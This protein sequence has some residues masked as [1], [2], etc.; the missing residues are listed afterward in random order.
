MFHNFLKLKFTKVNSV[1]VGRFLFCIIQLF[2][3]IFTL[4]RIVFVVIVK[5][6]SLHAVTKVKDNLLL[7]TVK[8]TQ[9][10]TS[11]AEE[12]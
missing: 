4:T 12:S 11:E 8:M 1:F 7:F 5:I 10:T 9:D 2:P 6:G 3:N